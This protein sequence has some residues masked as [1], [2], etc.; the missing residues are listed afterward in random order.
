MARKTQ[1]VSTQNYLKLNA[2]LSATLLSIKEDA[3]RQTGREYGTHAVRG[4]GAYERMLRDTLDASI[5]LVDQYKK[6]TS[7]ERDML[8]RRLIKDYNYGFSIREEERRTQEN[9]R[10]TP[11]MDQTK[12]TKRM[13]AFE[14]MRRENIKRVTSK[15]LGWRNKND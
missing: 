10:D 3:K 12:I 6:L 7:D 4:S 11:V 14:E 13:N 5:V 8:R 2:R 9:R 1:Q 15:F